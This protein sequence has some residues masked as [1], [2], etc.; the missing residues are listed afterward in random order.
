MVEIVCL[1]EEIWEIYSKLWLLELQGMKDDTS[2]NNL[3]ELL[4]ECINKEN[5]LFNN[6]IKTNKY[7]YDKIIDMIMS[8]NDIYNEDIKKRFYDYVMVY[9]IVY[10][11]NI[12]NCKDIDKLN[13]L[14]MFG[15]R[16]MYL[17]YFSYLEEFIDKEMD[18]KVKAELLNLKYIEAFYNH[19]MESMLM[20]NNFNVPINNYVDIDVVDS[21]VNLSYG[22]EEIKA[23]YTDIIMGIVVDMLEILDNDYYDKIIFLIKNQCMFRAC[24]SLISDDDFEKIDILKLLFERI[25]NDNKK[26]AELIISMINNRFNDMERVKR[27]SL[28]K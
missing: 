8:N 7:D 5:D 13:R 11:K 15:F 12:N 28:C 1:Y 4:N 21:L 6:L 19:D 20:I 9:K 22:M 25:N 3:V 18:V 23:N 10:S 16:N 27:I 2:F 26:S 14:Y 17:L 24:S